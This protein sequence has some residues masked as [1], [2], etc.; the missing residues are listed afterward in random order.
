MRPFGRVF[1][2]FTKGVIEGHIKPPTGPP[3][4]DGTRWNRDG[5]HLFQAYGLSAKLDQ[6]AAVG[7]WL[8]TL[9]LHREG[10]PPVSL[11]SVKFH[12]I[13]PANKPKPQ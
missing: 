3:I 7:F 4:K 9:M 5:Q 2:L 6:V 12:Y 13:G 1:R 11:S 10:L 8:T